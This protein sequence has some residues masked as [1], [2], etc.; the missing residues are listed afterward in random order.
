MFLSISEFLGG[1]ESF[2][3]GLNN[4]LCGNLFLDLALNSLDCVFNL[5]NKVLEVFDLFLNSL[6][7]VGEE[8]VLLLSGNLG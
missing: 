8:I 4:L 3:L 2:F 5:S 6:L 7:L 1:L